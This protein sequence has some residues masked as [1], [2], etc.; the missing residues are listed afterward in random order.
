M[1]EQAKAKKTIQGKVVSD[2]M[3]KTAVILVE[4]MQNHPKFKKITR[5]SRR[6]KIHD[7]KNECKE[8]D[9]VSAVETRPISKDKRH[10]LYKII[11]RAK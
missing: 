2:K 1:E 4:T 3:D 10:K 5:H 11:E 8:G 6:I 9:R 7:D